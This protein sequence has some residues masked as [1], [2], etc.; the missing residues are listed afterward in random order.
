MKQ[1]TFSLA[2]A[3]CVVLSIAPEA[4]A[5]YVYPARGQSPSTQAKD[6]SECARWATKQTGYDP[7]QPP[8]PAPTAEPAPVTGTGS[9]ARGAAAGAALGAIGGNAGAGA[10]TGAIV[11]G[12]ARRAAN[13][14]AAEAQNQAS[15]QQAQSARASFD[16]ARTACLTGRGYSVR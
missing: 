9:R 12:V 7:A 2:T 11:G 5:Q 3:I 8:P 13:R 4:A 1:A 10:A 16:Q 6:K 14:R 15:A